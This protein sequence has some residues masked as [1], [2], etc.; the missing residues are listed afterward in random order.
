MILNTTLGEEAIHILSPVSHGSNDLIQ[1][2]VTFY[3]KGRQCACSLP[4]LKVSTARPIRCRA[5]T[6]LPCPSGGVCRPRELERLTRRSSSLLTSLW[7]LIPGKAP[8]SS[9]ALSSLDFFLEKRRSIS[10]WQCSDRVGF[11]L[12]RSVPHGRLPTAF[13]LA[14]PNTTEWG[15]HNFQASFQVSLFCFL[16]VGRV[17]P[18]QRNL[19]FNLCEA[20]EGQWN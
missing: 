14:S 19:K 6:V 13:R 20:W 15:L 4:L 7:N 18:K 2:A 3:L 11:W 5:R 17:C 8:V 1:Q 10:Y 9:P 12:K 16:F